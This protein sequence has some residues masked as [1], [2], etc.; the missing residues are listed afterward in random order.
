MAARDIDKLRIAACSPDR[1]H[2][3][4][5]PDGKASEPEPQAEANRARQRAIDDG[6]CARRTAEQD[7][8]GA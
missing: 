7:V 3:A 1:K 6:E 4:D 5:C 2:M 8:F